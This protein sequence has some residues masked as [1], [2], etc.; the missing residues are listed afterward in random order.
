M[1][2]SYRGGAVRGRALDAPLV[3]IATAGVE[4]PRAATAAATPGG[5]LAEATRALDARRASYLK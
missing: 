4:L 3:E 2:A 1:R 5:A